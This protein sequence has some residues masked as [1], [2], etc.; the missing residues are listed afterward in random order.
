[1]NHDF[2]CIV[3]QIYEADKR[4]KEDAYVFVMEALSYT[5]RKFRSPKHVS[6]E[7]M[8]QGMKELLIKRYGPMTMSVLKYWGIQSTEDFGN[9]VFNLVE[10]KV[11]TKTEDDN[12][13]HFRNG[14]N[15]DDVFNVGYRKLLHKKISRMR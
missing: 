10:N 14:Y 1:M 12:I 13:D 7:E 4:Y 9:I 11:L 5:Q 3:E 8:L 15:F 2:E 6:G